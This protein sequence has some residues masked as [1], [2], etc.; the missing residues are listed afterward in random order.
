LPGPADTGHDSHQIPRVRIT[1]M[2]H[3][4]EGPSAPVARAIGAVTSP[5]VARSGD[6]RDKAVEAAAGGD[7]LRL[8]GEAASLQ[9]LQRDLAARPAFDEARVAALRESIGSGSYK[10][11]AEAIASRMLDLDARLGG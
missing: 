5:Q 7:S 1:D 11:D 3:K 6:P 9:V 2:T 8:T 10:I 4:I